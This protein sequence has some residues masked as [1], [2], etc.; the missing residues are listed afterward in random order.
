MWGIG[1]DGRRE[2]GVKRIVSVSISLKT[3]VIV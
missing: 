3:A 1:R 2:R